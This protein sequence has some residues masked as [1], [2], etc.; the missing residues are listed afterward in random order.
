MSG[1]RRLVLWPVPYLASCS[2]CYVL[3]VSSYKVFHFHVPGTC[4]LLLSS[5]CRLMDA[6]LVI[7]C[8]ATTKTFLCADVT[9]IDLFAVFSPSIPCKNY[10]LV[11]TQFILVTFHYFVP[12]VRNMKRRYC[13]NSQ[14]YMSRFFQMNMN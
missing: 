5:V 6:T 9:P 4:T 12:T 2:S 7:T 11:C 8:R 13:N 3:K 14:F 1:I 10:Y